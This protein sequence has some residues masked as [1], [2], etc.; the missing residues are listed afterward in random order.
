MNLIITL[1]GE[2]PLPNLM[3]LWQYRNFDAVQFVI[4]E[5]TRELAETLAAYLPNDPQ[6]H[7]LHRLP[8]LLVPPY[9]LP[10]ARLKIGEC[11]LQSL[12][13]GHAVTLNLTGGTKLMCLAAMQAAYGLAVPLLYVSSESGEMIF[14]TSDGVQTRREPIDLCISVEQYL[15]AHGIEV[16]PH[17]S[18]RPGSEPALRPPK[19]GDLL[20]EA[21]FEAARQSGQFDDVRHNLYIRRHGRNG[22]VDNE[23]DVLVTRNG[24]LAVCSCKS[25]K[26]SI[27]DLYELEALSSREKFGIYC[28]KVFAASQPRLSPGFLERAAADRVRLA[29]GSQVEAVARKAV[30]QLDQSMKRF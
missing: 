11:L 23:L 7:N 13:V 25:G 27:S 6:L 17:Q 14:Y 8:P 12:N 26:V 9:D 30:D 28:G 16:S 20:E 29:Y 1:L 15:R 18:F 4:S 21:V 22:D 2:Q 10:A 19:E 5:R 24:M 3:P